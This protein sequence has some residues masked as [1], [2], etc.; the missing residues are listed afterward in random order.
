HVMT[1]AGPAA[2]VDTL[3]IDLVDETDEKRDRIP[4]L[5]RMAER[6]VRGLVRGTGDLPRL[7]L[8]DVVL[9]SSRCDEGD[10]SGVAIADFSLL[11]SGGGATISSSG[12]VL[13]TP[14][15]TYT[16]ALD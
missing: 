1:A 6:W 11:P 3:D 5:R 13:L 15:A 2:A 12:T 16:A 7:A 9:A 8:R 4:G 10:T 14:P